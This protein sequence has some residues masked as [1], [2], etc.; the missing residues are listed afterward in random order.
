M[1]CKHHPFADATASC[2]ACSTPICGV[3]SN[4]TAKAVYCHNCVN[5]A[6]LAERHAPKE[7]VAASPK[8]SAA[9]SAS[10]ST[11][12]KLLQEGKSLRTEAPAGESSKPKNRSKVWDI[13]HVVG[14]FGCFVFLGVR[15]FL[16]SASV[17]TPAD[18]SRQEQS[19]AQLENCILVFW[20]IADTLKNNR[21]P[22][23]FKNCVEAGGPNIIARVDGDI[24]VRHPRPDMY[25]YAD[26]FVTK[27]NP[28]PILVELPQ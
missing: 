15:F 26:I 23:P 22:D 5:T 25:G 17:L 2:E 13:L 11:M 21:E 7:R 3:C 27:N 24:I 20:E 16:G 18:I 4:Y 8:S 9:A 19:R 12:G 1:K 6:S 14:I 10:T 28:I